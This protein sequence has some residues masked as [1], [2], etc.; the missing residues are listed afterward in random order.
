M[1]TKLKNNNADIMTMSSMKRN[2][3]INPNAS[4]WQHP[5]GHSLVQFNDGTR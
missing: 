3:N 2:G 4:L 1:L 5:Y